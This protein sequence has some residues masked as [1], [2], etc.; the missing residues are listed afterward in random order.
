MILRFPYLDER[1]RGPAPPS[2]PAGSLVRHRPL[3]PVTIRG[4]CGQWSFT[5]AVLDPGSDDTIF[6]LSS[7]HWIGASLH[8][9][10]GHRIR[11]RGPLH[12]LRFAD[13]ELELD[14]GSCTCRWQAVVAFSPAPMTYPLLGL[15]G[16]LEFFDAQFRG[17]DRLA[18]LETNRLFPGTTS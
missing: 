6:P 14:D 17:A 1:L 9:D 8:P 5:R 13:I 12:P 16:C 10:T 2:L 18:E 3:A 15:A 11:W 4:P 7:V